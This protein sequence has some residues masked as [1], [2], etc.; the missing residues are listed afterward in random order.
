MTGKQ[1]LK[2][3]MIPLTHLLHVG[4]VSRTDLIAA[5]LGKQRNAVRSMK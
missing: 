4:Q 2:R 1:A 5:C 3:R